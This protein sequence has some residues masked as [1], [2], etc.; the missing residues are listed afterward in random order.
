MEL[1]EDETDAEGMAYVAESVF[2]ERTGE[3]LPAE[4]AEN[5]E[6]SGIEWQEEGDDLA[7]M[8]PKLWVKYNDSR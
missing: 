1:E 4:F 2:K 8:F 5:H 3:A 6:I 7:R